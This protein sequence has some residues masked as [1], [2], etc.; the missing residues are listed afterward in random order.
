MKQGTNRNNSL[1]WASNSL[2]REC[3]VSS[4]L[5]AAKPM[6]LF[7][8]SRCAC[9]RVCACACV[10]CCMREILPGDSQSA[11]PLPNALRLKA[12]TRN[13]LLPAQMGPR[14]ICDHG[15]SQNSPT[16]GL[17]FRSRRNQKFTSEGQFSRLAS[18]ESCRRVGPRR[19]FVERCVQSVLGNRRRKLE[20]LISWSVTLFHPFHVYAKWKNANRFCFS[21]QLL[22]T[23]NH[24]PPL[25][26]L[27]HTLFI[28]ANRISSLLLLQD[29]CILLPLYS[30]SLLQMISVWPPVHITSQ[31][32]IS[33]PIHSG[34]SKQ[35]L[36]SR[37]HPPVVPPPPLNQT[38]SLMSPASI[39]SILVYT[40]LSHVSTDSLSNQLFHT[41]SVGQRRHLE[42]ILAPTWEDG[43][44]RI[45][46]REIFFFMC[47][48]RTQHCG[49]N[50]VC[51]QCYQ[52]TLLSTIIFTR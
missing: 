44:S 18:D 10:V 19:A 49:C 33:D 20:E 29:S 22:T 8:P 41:L 23:A 43:R 11:R 15:G 39:P 5:C 7:S 40:L 12:L 17:L 14:I 13:V 28:Y 42:L 32:Y 31:A 36:P 51:W 46:S 24:L 6:A 27:L 34:H 9:V 38:T 37:L 47:F 21:S 30:L 52:T 25:N 26:Q 4:P 35:P 16:Q 1:A 45:R 50:G 2:W 3:C 48:V